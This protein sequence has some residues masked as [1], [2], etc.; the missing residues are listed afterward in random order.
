MRDKHSENSNFEFRISKCFNFLR[1]RDLLLQC[2]RREIE[3]RYRGS[4]L[5]VLWALLTPLL[6]LGVFTLVFSVIFQARWSATGSETHAE[7]ALIIFSGMIAFNVFSECANRAPGLIVNNRNYVKKVVFPLEILPVSVLGSSLVHSFLSL[8]VVVLALLL[9]HGQVYWSALYL[10][11][12]YIP[13]AALALGTGWF[14]SSLGVFLRDLENL[15]PVLTQLWFF[16]T[17]IVYP[18]SAVPQ[19]L[20]PWLQLNPLV[21][22]VE[23]LRRV[24][25]WGLPPEWG[26]LGILTLCSLVFMV[27]GYV[28]FMKIKGAFADVI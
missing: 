20:R 27:A 17:P 14:L 4:H 15:V 25:L 28:W 19:S 5:G 2:T 12:C 7:V 9:L 3:G 11:L 22:P 26:A 23:N 8:A 24:L 10:P 13:L 16:L 18:I 21:V 1:H 6:T